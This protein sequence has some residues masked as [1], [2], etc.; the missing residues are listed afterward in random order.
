MA[1]MHNRYPGSR[2]QSLF[3]GVELSLR[4]LFP[5]YRERARVLGLFH[6]GVNLVVLQAMME[7]ERMD[8]VTHFEYD[9]IALHPALCPHLRGQLDPTEHAELTDRWHRAMRVYVG[10]LDQQ[11]HEQAELAARLTRLELPNLLALSE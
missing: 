5:E 11:Q 1:E 3:T 9:Y 6:G 10:F 7:W 2:E 8:V 4:Q